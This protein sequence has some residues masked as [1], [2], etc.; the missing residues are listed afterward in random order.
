MAHASD[1]SPPRVLIVNPKGGCGKT[2]VATNL[3]TIYAHR[4]LAA[5]LFDLDPQ[6]S[7]GEWLARRDANLPPVTVV[8][9]HRQTSGGITRTF[10]LRLPLDAERIITDTPAGVD[11]SKLGDLM[12]RSRV[13]LVPVL[14]SAIDMRAAAVF[15]GT[16]LKLR[17]QRQLRTP[18]AVVANRVRK[19]T[20][21]FRKLITFLAKANVP[22]IATFHDMQAYVHATDIGQ[23]VLELGGRAAQDA[24][25]WSTLVRWIEGQIAA[26]DEAQDPVEDGEEADPPSDHPRPISNISPR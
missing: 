25:Q 21:M 13:V 3:A 2:T 20:L 17:H 5:T 22:L 7:S 18:I 23:G 19:N 10:Q 24:G 15:L 4:G 12:R 16:L 8:E 1:N 14:P 26:Q 9:A 6:G 11:A